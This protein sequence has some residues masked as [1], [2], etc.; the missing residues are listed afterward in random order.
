MNHPNEMLNSVVWQLNAI[1]TKS[2]ES[3]E[4]MLESMKETHDDLQKDNPTLFGNFEDE[5]IH[6]TSPFTFLNIEYELF[7]GVINR[8]VIDGGGELITNA[9]I[10]YAIYDDVNLILGGQEHDPIFLEGLRLLPKPV[11]DTSAHYI[12]YLGS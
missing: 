1:E 7:T 2:I 9:E 3:V 4:D 5:E 8:L 10:A 6:L 12:A 11:T